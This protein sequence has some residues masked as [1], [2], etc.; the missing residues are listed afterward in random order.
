MTDDLSRRSFLTTSSAA[1]T[2]TLA[3]SV[4]AGASAEERVP[5]R[6]RLGVVGC[7]GIMNYHVRGLCERKSAVDFRW[8]CDVDPRQMEIISKPIKSFQKTAPKLTGKYEDVLDDSKVDAILIATPHQWHCP[9]ALRAIAAG[10]DVYC[11]KP[12]SHV[13]AEGPLVVA[14]AKKRKRVVQHGSQMRS[15]PVTKMAGKLLKD[16]LIGDIK[17]SPRV[18]GGSP[19]RDEARFR[20]QGARRRRL[21]PLARTRPEAVLQQSPLSPHLADVP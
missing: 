8:L 16:G 11:E 7:G 12:L 9:I 15:S 13:F 6:I 10:K 1:A 4:F 21:R 14:E 18:D 20:Q 17:V 5:D 2:G 3:A 19:Q